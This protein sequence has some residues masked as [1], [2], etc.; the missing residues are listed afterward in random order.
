MTQERDRSTENSTRAFAESTTWDKVAEDY[1]DLA[2]PFTRQYA[3]AALAL[4]GGVRPGERVLDVAAG[5]GA[6]ALEA[7][8][9]GARVLATDFSPG[10]VARLADRFREH[11]AEGSE[12]RVMDGQ[13]L[14]LAD[15]S[16]DAAFAMFGVMMFH[17]WRRGLSELARVVRP[18]GRGCVGVWAQAEGAG[19]TPVF[20]ETY[21]RVLPDKP[22]PPTP[23]AM[24]RL[25]DPAGFRA[26]MEAAGFRDVVV[27][28]ISGVY[29][30][31]S[32]GWMAENMDRVFRFSP[33]YTDLDAEGKRRIDAA[34][35]T[36]WERYETPE[37]IR[38]PSDAHIAVGRR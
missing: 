4:A 7:A 3:T 21:R 15:A 8:R 13:A 38:I 9:C 10:M 1:E 27:Q 32:A 29:E 26:E 23:P 30:V 37:G 11:G 16:F 33:L 22:I 2:E 36:A 31:P 24:T 5:T 20:H 28:T 17:D 12:A 35:E 6:L 34:I 19:P 18:G 14:D 25:A